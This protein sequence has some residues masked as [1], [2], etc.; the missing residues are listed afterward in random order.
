MGDLGNGSNPHP[1]IAENRNWMEIAK[2]WTKREKGEKGRRKGR[3]EADHKVGRGNCELRKWSAN[4]S[5]ICFLLKP[6]KRLRNSYLRGRISLKYHGG[7]R[8]LV[9]GGESGGN[10]SDGAPAGRPGAEPLVGSGA[11]P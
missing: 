7:S 10:G 9:R 5:L 11:K 2:K 8:I 6:T 1:Q 3:K 4:W